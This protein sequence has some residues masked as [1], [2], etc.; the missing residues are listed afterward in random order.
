MRPYVSLYKRLKNATSYKLQAIPPRPIT[1]ALKHALHDVPKLRE[2]HLG[3]DT[4]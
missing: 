4:A 3:P 2:S 1:I